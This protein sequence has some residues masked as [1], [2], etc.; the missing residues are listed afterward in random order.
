MC[1]LWILVLRYK[2]VTNNEMICVCINGHNFRT[3]NIWMYIVFLT[4]EYMNME[5]DNLQWNPHTHIYLTADRRH[6][7]SSH[8]TKHKISPFS[9]IAKQCASLDISD[10]LYVHP[11]HYMVFPWVDPGGRLP[12]P[13][14][15]RFSMFLNFKF[16]LWNTY[17]LISFDF[18]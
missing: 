12:P 2:W 16:P 11:I 10:L 8:L 3:S 6:H 1:S 15:F 18:Y 17:A 4:R 13:F 14:I 7:G 5:G 9:Q